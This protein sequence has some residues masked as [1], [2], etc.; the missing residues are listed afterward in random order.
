MGIEKL[1]HDA[2]LGEYVQDHFVDRID[3]WVCLLD[4]VLHCVVQR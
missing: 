2:S 1:Y 4:G 3:G